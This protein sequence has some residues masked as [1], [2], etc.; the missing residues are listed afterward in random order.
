MTKLT[1]EMK[2]ARRAELAYERAGFRQDEVKVY[3]NGARNPQR[4]LTVSNRAINEFNEDF[5][6]NYAAMTLAQRDQLAEITLILEGMGFNREDF[7]FAFGAN[8]CHQKGEGQE[9]LWVGTKARSEADIL[10]GHNNKPV[11]LC[12]HNTVAASTFLRHVKTGAPVF[13][14]D[15]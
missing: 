9:V 8:E 3:Q 5:T 6:K 11:T 14:R 15:F 12:N 7:G 10:I 2:A 13:A 4:S 1:P